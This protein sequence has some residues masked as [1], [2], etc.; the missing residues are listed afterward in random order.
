VP[1]AHCSQP[2]IRERDRPPAAGRSANW[3]ATTYRY[4]ATQ[5]RGR[6][7][8]SPPNCRPG[9]PLSPDY[10]DPS[11]SIWT[12]Y[13]DGDKW[14][15]QRV[16]DIPAETAKP[17]QTS[18]STTSISMCRA[19]ADLQQSDVSDPFHPE[20]TG[21]V[22][23][24]GIVARAPHP[25]SKRPLRGGAADGRGEPRRQA[26]LL[27]QFTVQGMPQHAGRGHAGKLRLPTDCRPSD[28]LSGL[29]PVRCARSAWSVQS[30]MHGTGVALPRLRRDQPMRYG[31]ES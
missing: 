13:R 20:L 24:G 2:A 7:T 27:H 12:W 23:I 14:A 5:C 17:D 26:D 1:L 9:F 11:S 8:M 25:R 30:S 21:K 19:G 15:V 3:R 22:R 4:M 18:R 28:R 29:S 10:K 6:D 16:I 31:K